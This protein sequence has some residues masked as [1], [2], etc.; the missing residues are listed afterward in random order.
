MV[1]GLS[2]VQ[3]RIGD[4]EAR[5]GALSARAPI[6]LPEASRGSGPGLAG[7][8]APTVFPGTGGLGASGLAAGGLVAGGSGARATFADQYARALATLVPGGSAPATGVAPGGPAS[9]VGGWGAITAPE[10]LRPYGNGRIP[11]HALVPIGV[12]SHRLHAPAAAAYQRMVADA[13]AQGVTIG[14]TDSYRPF[15]EQVDLARRK[16]LYRE[17]GLAAVPGT[18]SHGWGLAVD[19]DL[20]ETAQQWMRENGWRYGWVE[21]TPREPWHWEYRAAA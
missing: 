1:E 21:T 14:I 13:R 18:S 19:L 16:G 11:D 3:A 2:R 4:I 12:G 20:D 10:S 9:G 6:S 5:L 17:G 8:A 7:A 15:D